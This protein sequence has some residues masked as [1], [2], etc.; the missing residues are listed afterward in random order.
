[1]IHGKATQKLELEDVLLVSHDRNSAN[2]TPKGKYTP[3]CQNILTSPTLA[4]LGIFITK[5]KFRATT[6]SKGTMQACIDIA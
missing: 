5:D 6:L 2:L 4:G 1:M 3:L